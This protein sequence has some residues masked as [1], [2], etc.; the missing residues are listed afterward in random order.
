[1]K[2][3]R[4]IISH[5]AEGKTK[6]ITGGHNYE[7]LPGEVI[8]HPPNIV[9]SEINPNLGIH[10]YLIFEAKLSINIDLLN[11]FPLYPVIRLENAEL[12]R[13]TMHELCKCFNQPQDEWRDFY[14]YSLTTS[15]FMMLIKSWHTMG[16]PKRPE[17]L[18]VP[19]EKLIHII[20]YMNTNYQKKISRTDLAEVMHVHPSHLDKKFRNAFK[21]TLMEMLREIRVKKAAELLQTSD[22][23]LESVAS[24]CGLVDATYLSR[25]FK[26]YFGVSPGEYRRQRA[27]MK[28]DWL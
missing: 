28:E 7:V 10:Q 4:W 19:Q 20:D 2:Y 13:A 15:I 17:T 23:S 9:F 27:K 11:L 14:V 25:N 24:M 22:Y 1:V 3:N 21:Q 8:I 18:M 6:L 5:V 12:F 26:H 16:K